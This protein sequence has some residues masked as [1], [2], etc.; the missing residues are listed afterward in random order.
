MKIY[1]VHLDAKHP[2]AIDKAVFMKEGFSFYAFLFHF[3]WLLY[4]RVWVKGGIV[5]AVFLLFSVLEMRGIIPPEH[6]AILQLGLQ[7]YVGFL[8]S[9]WRRRALEK[10]GYSFAGVSSGRDEI[11]A[12]QRFFDRY[13]HVPAVGAYGA[14]VPL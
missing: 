2:Q 5:F 9:D 6:S 1:T 10:T 4:H 12:Q 8:A 11:D 3:F 7:V 13:T 14:A